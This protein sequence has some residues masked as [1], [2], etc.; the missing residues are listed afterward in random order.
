MTHTALGKGFAAHDARRCPLIVL[1]SLLLMWRRS[2]KR[3][4]IGRTASV[5]LRSV[6]TLVLGLGGWFGG[7]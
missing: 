1:L 2:R 7:L 6:Y 4:R 5:L 3:G